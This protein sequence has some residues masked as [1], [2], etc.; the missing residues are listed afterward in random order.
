MTV[1]SELNAVDRPPGLPEAI[2]RQVAAGVYR[3]SFVH[4]DFEIDDP[5]L[6]ANGRL[7]VSP[8][9]YGFA[10]RGFQLGKTA[11]A[12][13]FANGTM[14]VVNADGQ[15]HV[16][17][18]KVRAR[19]LFISPEGAVLQDSAVMQRES[20]SAPELVTVRLTVNVTFDLNGE[21]PE[22]ARACLIRSLEDAMVRLAAL[23]ETAARVVDH[24]FE[25]V[26]VVPEAR[27]RSTDTDFSQ[28]LD[29]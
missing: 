15:S 26:A 3:Y 2:R 4:D 23:T 12:R 18:T 25:Q 22:A 1:W 6:D 19:I 24:S 5:S 7:F 16:L 13:D 17:S 28:L 20:R 21:S 27:V 14:L 8:R 10:I 29:L 11:W 9:E